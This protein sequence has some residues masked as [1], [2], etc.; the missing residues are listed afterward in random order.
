MTI[1]NTNYKRLIRQTSDTRHW[2]SSQT[3]QTTKKSFADKSSLFTTGS[4]VH[5][6]SCDKAPPTTHCPC[7][8]HHHTHTCT[9]EL[10]IP[11]WSARLA[12]WT[13]SGPRY[14]SPTADVSDQ[15]DAPSPTPASLPLLFTE[16][17]G[18]AS[19]GM[20][21]Q[22][23]VNKLAERT[24]WVP[25]RGARCRQ[26]FITDAKRSIVLQLPTFSVQTPRQ[27][28]TTQISCW[29]PGDRPYWSLH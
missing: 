26:L 19:S 28:L 29:S 25:L 12:R 16:A 1:I 24:R 7:H 8:H 20:H 27:Q 4:C 13:R 17:K 9:Q 21:A 11:G 3:Y 10:A 23:P 18:L 5:A 2:V 6:S 22:L 14:S 15:Q